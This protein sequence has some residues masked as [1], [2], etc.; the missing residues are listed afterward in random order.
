MIIYMDV[1]GGDS[2]GAVAD[3][4]IVKGK[5]LATFGADIEKLARA[6]TLILHTRKATVGAVTAENSHP[7]V[8][9]D[10]TGVHNGSVSNYRALNAKLHRDLDVDSMH[11]YAHM[12]EGRDLGELSVRGAIVYL[13]AKEPEKLFLDRLSSGSL[14]IV[15]VESLKAQT[16][17]FFASTPSAV[18]A[19]LTM[20]AVP[21]WFPYTTKDNIRYHAVNGRLFHDTPNVDLGFGKNVLDFQYGAVSKTGYYSSTDRDSRAAGYTSNFVTRNFIAEARRAGYLEAYYGNDNCSDCSITAAVRAKATGFLYCTY[22]WLAYEKLG[23]F[24]KSQQQKGEPEGDPL[25]AG[26]ISEDITC[27]WNCDDQPASWLVGWQN[28]GWLVCTQCKGYVDAPGTMSNG[29]WVMELSDFNVTADVR[30]TNKCFCGLHAGVAHYRSTTEGK[31]LWCCQACLKNEIMVD[32]GNEPEPKSKTDA[33]KREKMRAH[34][35]I[36]PPPV[37]DDHK[38]LGTTGKLSARKDGIVRHNRVGEAGWG[39]M[40]NDLFKRGGREH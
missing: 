5:G 21:K 32:L 24:A 10:F 4:D 23:F 31:L 18:N 8:F 38:P 35:E 40:I 1:R 11:I 15:G 17:V 14:S 2:W 36:V 22:C 6:Q 7:F 20:A 27:E 39:E 33:E 34:L 30:S 29:S 3:G 25:P 37:A 28:S 9:G 26:A 12:A 13:D 19:G 16:D